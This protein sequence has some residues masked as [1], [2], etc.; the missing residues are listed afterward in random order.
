MLAQG[1]ATSMPRTLSRFE[2]LA[3]LTIPQTATP[4]RTPKERCKSIEMNCFGGSIIPVGGGEVFGSS[5]AARRG[6]RCGAPLVIPRQIGYTLL[7]IQQRWYRAVGMR[8]GRQT[9]PVGIQDGRSCGSGWCSA[10]R[11]GCWCK[12]VS[13][14]RI[15]IHSDLRSDG[16]KLRVRGCGHKLCFI[17]TPELR[18]S[19]NLTFGQQDGQASVHFAP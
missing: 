13:E 15:Q 1:A 10:F 3:T 8:A 18:M 4:T 14:R 19:H 11:L 16:R 2:P 17:G 12:P 5:R 9:R 7:W 6:G